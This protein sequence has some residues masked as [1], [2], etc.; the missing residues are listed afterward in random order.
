MSTN[1]RAKKKKEFE[2]I[3]K[4]AYWCIYA[5]HHPACAHIQSA[6]THIHGHI[7][8]LFLCM[9]MHRHAYTNDV[10]K[11]IFV[12]TSPTCMHTHMHLH[13]CGIT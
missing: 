10:V 7:S 8:I 4:H 3:C 13:L 2:E 1:I 11:F 12:C 9:S 6:P 5:S